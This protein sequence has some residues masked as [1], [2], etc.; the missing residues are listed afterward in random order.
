MINV[1]PKQNILF[2]F[3][4]FFTV[5]T[6][7]TQ[8]IVSVAVPLC[9]SVLMLVCIK[10]VNL[11]RINWRELFF[12]IF[13]ILSYVLMLSVTVFSTSALFDYLQIRRA[14]FGIILFLLFVAVTNNITSQQKLIFINAIES[15]LIFH[16]LIFFTQFLMY[17][18]FSIKLDIIGLFGFQSNSELGIGNVIFYRASGLYLEPG[19]F[20]LQLFFLYVCLALLKKTSWTI[21]LV[22]ALALVST[23]SIFSILFSIVI[24]A[25]RYSGNGKSNFISWL[26]FL[27]F[28]VMGCFVYFQD[29][30]I[31][32]FLERSDGSLEVKLE[33]VYW[34]LSWDYFKYFLG[35][36]LANNSHFLVRD[37]TLFFNFIF[38]GGLIGLV[39]VFVYFIIFLKRGFK[40]IIL[41]I[42]VFL[43]KGDYTYMTFWLMTALLISN[44]EEDVDKSYF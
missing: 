16:V 8:E 38:T 43:S 27:C 41:F 44:C 40:Y 23:Y 37:S 28:F 3:I 19:T 39:N 1:K 22:I 35:N 14:L 11:I 31:S 32:R 5:L 12:S 10:P 20:G 9:F 42:G 24:I 18:L 21:T 2:F 25:H 33:V 15:V 36:G 7:S 30:F 13:I 6:L 29:Y 26:V 17:H 34:F 4:V